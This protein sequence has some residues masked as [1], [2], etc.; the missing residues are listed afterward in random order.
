MAHRQ[1]KLAGGLDTVDPV[2][3]RVRDEAAEIAAHEPPLASFIF[4]TVLNHDTLERTIAQRVADRLDH[5]NVPGELIVQA[6]DDLFDAEPQVGDAFRADIVAVAERDPATHRY[7]EP[8]LYYKGFHALQAHRLAHFLWH[9]GRKDFALYIQ[10]RMSSIFGVDINPATRIGRGVFIDHGTGVVIGATAVIEDDVSLLQ[11]VTLGG[12]GKEKGDRHPK[13]RK[14]VLIGAGA[15][16]LG[17][18]EVG[19]CSRVAAGSVVLK[20]VPPNT[21]VAGIPAR[22]VGKADCGDSPARSMDQF[23]EMPTFAGEAI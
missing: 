15:K 6:Y 5:P 22:V 12:T 23:F 19:S 8:V 2:W 17:N 14:G 7:V 21:T 4:A 20:A 11:G 9:R 10:S 18:I 16:V 3:A 13:I 1:P